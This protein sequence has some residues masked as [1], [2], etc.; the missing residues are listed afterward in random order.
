MRCVWRYETP[1]G[2]LG[3]AEKDCGISHI[4]FENQPAPPEYE[5]R[6]TPLTR[7]AAAQL[8]A[9]FA[10]ERKAF[11]LPILPEGTAFQRMVWDTLLT[12]K[13]GEIRTY[14]Q[15]AAQIKRPAAVRAVGAA[16]GR[17]PIPIIIPCHRVIGSDGSLTG[18]AGGLAAKQYL[19]EQERKHGG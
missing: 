12:I 18:Y 6:E 4:L 17:N 8:S 15:V 7:E 1:I 2:K 11:D 16:N 14:Q 9:Y 13:A 3:I 19:L 10:G 5:M